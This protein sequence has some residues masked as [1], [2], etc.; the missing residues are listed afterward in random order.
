MLCFPEEWWYVQLKSCF[1][2]DM[3]W[4]AAEEL[5]IEII[6][7]ENFGKINISFSFKLTFLFVIFLF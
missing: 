3:K 5:V 7:G 6:C 2:S 4:L 1:A